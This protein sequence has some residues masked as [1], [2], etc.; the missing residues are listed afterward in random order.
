MRA[1]S[2]LNEIMPMNSELENNYGHKFKAAGMSEFETNP[3]AE[4]RN[5][6]GI[7]YDKDAYIEDRKIEIKMIF[8]NRDLEEAIKQRNNEK[9]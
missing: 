6:T 3:T 5:K 7:P 9:K 2:F 8:S 4:E 1:I